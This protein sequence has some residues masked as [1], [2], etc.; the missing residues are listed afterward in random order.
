ML[1]S[2][3]RVAERSGEAASRRAGRPRG[4]D[5][6]RA[7]ESASQLRLS[8]PGFE[9]VQPPPRRP[10]PWR[11]KAQRAPVAVPHALRVPAHAHAIRSALP[12][13]APGKQGRQADSEAMSLALA[14]VVQAGWK[15]MC[16][17]KVAASMLEVRRQ[18]ADNMK[19]RGLCACS[20][21]HAHVQGNQ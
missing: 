9:E 16:I 17:C 7:A 19:A 13:M 1:K 3:Q 18:D 14:L 10:K 4:P 15:I 20:G 8:G 21:L 11:R 6:R 2:G 5:A 12:C